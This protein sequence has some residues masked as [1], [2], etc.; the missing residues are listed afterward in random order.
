M[1]QAI[2]NFVLAPIAAIVLAIPALAQ[3]DAFELPPGIENTPIPRRLKSSTRAATAEDLRQIDQYSQQIESLYKAKNYAD[4]EPLYLRYITTLERIAPQSSAYTSA[5]QNYAD[6]LRKLGKEAEA[7]AIE[8]KATA[9]ITRS[10]KGDVTYGLKEYRLGMSLDDFAKLGVPAGADANLVKSICSCD[11]NQNAEI[12]TKSDRDANVI[13]C[14][15]WQKGKGD[16]NVPFKITVAGFQCA[17]DFRFIQEN[18]IFRL[19]E[20]NV[21]LYSSNYGD[22]KRA[23]EGKYGQPA[24]TQVEKMK[25]EMGNI[26]PVTN[27]IWDNGISRIKLTNADGTNLGR[28]RL[29]FVHRQLFLSYAKRVNDAGDSAVKR[30]SDDL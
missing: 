28:A 19:Y 25:T 24:Q 13:Q 16:V 6:L 12:L 21:S 27:L 9:L 7:G 26:F 20:I 4:A 3:Y 11:A 14:G 30:A 22:M 2:K 8:V 15:F 29:R 10:Q 23:L 5:L 1:T 17:P 18:G